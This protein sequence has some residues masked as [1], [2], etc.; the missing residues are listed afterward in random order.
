[1]TVRLVKKLTLQLEPDRGVNVLKL[2]TKLV[3]LPAAVVVLDPKGKPLRAEHQ[4]FLTVDSID[5]VHA[6]CDIRRADQPR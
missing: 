6:I 2:G 3:E 4:F 1:M 5:P